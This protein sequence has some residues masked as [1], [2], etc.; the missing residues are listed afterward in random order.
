MHTKVLEASV[1]YK[2]KYVEWRKTHVNSPSAQTL[3]PEYVQ[4]H[5]ELMDSK[6]IS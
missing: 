1:T 3:A 2:E 4:L 6:S 5:L